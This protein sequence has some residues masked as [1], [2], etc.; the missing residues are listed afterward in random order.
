MKKYIALLCCLLSVLSMQA[1][2]KDEQKDVETL[3]EWFK[4]ASG[5]DRNYPR[6]KVYLHLDNTSYMAGDTLWYKAYVV[7]A[8]SLLPTDVSGVL[9]VDLLNADGQQMERQMLHIDSLGQADGA[10]LLKLPIRAG[11]YEVRAYTRAMTNWEGYFSRIVPVFESYNPQKVEHALAAGDASQLTLPSPRSHDKVTLGAP[12]PYIMGSKDERLLTF[13]PEGGARAKGVA[14]RIAYELTDGRGMATDDT[15]QLYDNAQHLITTFAPLHAG[16]G[17]FQLPQNLQGGYICL[18]GE[19]KQYALPLATANYGLRAQK[20]G[21]GLLLTILA[22][23]SVCQQNNLLGLAVLSREKVCYFDTLTVNECE[24]E[25]FIPRKALRGGVNRVELYDVSGH[26]Q[27]TRLVW[28]TPNSD[29]DRRV[30]V[31]LQQNEKVYAPFSPAVVTIDLHDKANRPVSTTFSVAVR[32]GSSNI[33]DTH[34]GGLEADLL[35]ASELRGYVARPDL[36]FEKDDA[37]HRQMLDLLLMVQGWQA[38]RFSVMCG[39]EPFSLQQPIEERPILR[40]Q[41]YAD[42]ARKKPR[43]NYQLNMLAYSLDGQT[44]QG[45]TRTDKEGRFAFENNAPFKGDFYA[46]FSQSSDTGKKPWSRL[47]IDQWFAPQPRAFTAQNLALNI[48]IAN[49]SIVTYQRLDDPETFAWRD[50]IP[51]T[52]PSKLSEASVSVVGKY[53]GLTGTR[54]TWLGGEN[55]GLERSTVYYNVSQIMQRLKDE[56]KPLPDLG[57]LLPMLDNHFSVQLYGMYRQAVGGAG[58][59]EEDEPDYEE[60]ERSAKYATGGDLFGGL[61]SEAQ[62]SARQRN[63]LSPAKGEIEKAQKNM[64]KKLYDAPHVNYNANYVT[65]FINNLPWYENYFL[66]YQ[67]NVFIQSAEGYKSITFVPNIVNENATTGQDKRLG[68]SE[69]DL[70]YV[71]EQPDLYRQNCKRGQDQRVLQGF[72]HHPQFYSPDYRRFD[73]PSSNDVRRT[74]YWNPSV[75]SDKEGKAHVLFFTNSRAEQWL[76]ISV[77]GLSKD[78]GVVEN[79]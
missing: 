26:S 43:A 25:L 73:L 77:R 29:E 41:L 69:K 39:A 71:Y 48:P 28:I 15:L 33:T 62:P 22:N 40:G 63:D 49:D 54:Y 50:T 2:N 74:L 19:K 13:Y 79:K 20:E 78:G 36:Y 45:K 44:M 67:D 72:A 1:Q 52:L 58:S 68:Y 64:M 16:R 12:R 31:H 4:K 53:H 14:Q 59:F 60:D 10:F 30:K 46:Q 38:N 61:K 7:R 37:A 75:K 32:D 34:D 47:S 51:R 76:D 57:E 3:F 66:R 8:S 56:G 65:M 9:Y 11:Y 23:D 5:F 27:V 24:T 42:N 18:K 21:D 70:L 35:L 17:Y 6:E 55:K